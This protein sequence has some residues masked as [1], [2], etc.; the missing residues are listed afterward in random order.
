MRNR[1]AVLTVAAIAVACTAASHA[2]VAP[3][4]AVLRVS[5]DGKHRQTLFTPRGFAIGDFSARRG[6]FLTESGRDLQLR[7]LH[8]SLLH[9]TVTMPEQI[10]TADWSPDATWIAF[11]VADLSTCALTSQA[12]AT[13]RLWLVHPDGS[14]L[15]KVA[16]NALSPAWSPDGRLLAYVDGFSTYDQLGRVVVAH[17]DGSSP[18]ALKARG[19]IVQ[20][21]WSPR[22]SQLAY[23]T[24]SDRGGITYVVPARE[25]AAA[26]RVAAGRPFAWSPTGTTIAIVRTEPGRG[27]HPRQDLELVDLRGHRRHVVTSSP[28][29]GF[30]SWSPDGRWIAFVRTNGPTAELAVVRPDGT[31]LHGL[32]RAPADNQVFWSEHGATLVVG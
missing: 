15:H 26:R 1:I 7:D 10:E 30:V 5:V 14:G 16:D 12:C 22:N 29:I 31:R 20:I 11:T 27:L 28:S 24:S 6:E 4:H 21:A 2:E 8:G 17:A 9:T 18:R 19:G 13:F 25:Q 32:V 3:Q 23:A